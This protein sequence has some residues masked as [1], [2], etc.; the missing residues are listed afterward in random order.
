MLDEKKMQ[1]LGYKVDK[2]NSTETLKI[3]KKMDKIHSELYSD[4]NPPKEEELISVKREVLKNADIKKEETQRRYRIQFDIGYRGAKGKTIDSNSLTQ[5][6]MSLTIRQLLED[7][8]RGKTNE[9]QIRQP[10]YFDM[11]IPQI[12]DITDVD[13][14]RQQLE[15]QLKNVNQFIETDK[16]KQRDEAEAKSKADQLARMQKEEPPETNSVT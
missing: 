5:P 1:E 8:T 10:L 9:V 16:K 3:H 2:E 11:E 13:N 15:D 14:F 4:Q 6:D 7:H 12:N